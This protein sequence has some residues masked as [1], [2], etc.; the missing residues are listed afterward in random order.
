MLFKITNRKKKKKEK[1]KKP[2]YMSKRK[3]KRLIGPSKILIGPPDF[4]D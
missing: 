1:L 3:P 2:W 4:I